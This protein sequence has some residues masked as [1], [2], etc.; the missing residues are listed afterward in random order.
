MG[1]GGEWHIIL[2]AHGKGGSSVAQQSDMPRSDLRR[3]DTM[4]SD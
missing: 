2:V 4:K 1:S 3:R